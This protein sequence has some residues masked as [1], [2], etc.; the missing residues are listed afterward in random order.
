MILAR[1]LNV[2]PAGGDRRG[3]LRSAAGRAL[4]SRATWTL[5]ERLLYDH[6]DPGDDPGGCLANLL[7]RFLANL[8][9]PFEGTRRGGRRGF[10]GAEAYVLGAGDGALHRIPRH[11]PDVSADIGGAL[12]KDA[13]AR[14][15]CV[16]CLDTDVLGAPGYIDDATLGWVA[17]YAPHSGGSRVGSAQ[18]FGH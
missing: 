6:L 4:A 16:G 7:H 12:Y 5:L 1:Q 17:P 8:T 3:R 13:G 14:S 11:Q 2:P 9:R 18:E 15:H 10:L